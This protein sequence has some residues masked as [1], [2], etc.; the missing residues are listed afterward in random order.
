M[1]WAS[2]DPYQSIVI[3]KKKINTYYPCDLLKGNEYQTSYDDEPLDEHG[4]Q[5]E[6]APEEVGGEEQQEEE[7]ED[8]A[9]GS[10]V[11]DTDEVWEDPPNKNMHL[12]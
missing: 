7:E 5:Q 9:E 6:A 11:F 1:Q 2:A 3:A 12:L 8:A 10:Q 4:V